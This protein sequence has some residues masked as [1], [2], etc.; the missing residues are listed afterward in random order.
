MKFDL[1]SRIERGLTTEKDARE[2]SALIYVV[3]ALAFLLSFL[4]VFSWLWLAG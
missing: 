2:V 4:L 3:V 1:I